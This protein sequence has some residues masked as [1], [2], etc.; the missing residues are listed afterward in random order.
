MGLKAGGGVGPSVN[1]T[2]AL[3]LDVV[4]ILVVVTGSV[5]K[6][7]ACGVAWW[8]VRATSLLLGVGLGDDFTGR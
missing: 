4:Y 8:V 3:V 2:G 1:T 7:A 5:G 6:I